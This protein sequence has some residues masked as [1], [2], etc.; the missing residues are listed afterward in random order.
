[1]P[2]SRRWCWS[3][4]IAGNVGV[5]TARVE[6]NSPATQSTGFKKNQLGSTNKIHRNSYQAHE[7]HMHMVCTSLE[8]VLLVDLSDK[9]LSILPKNAL[10]ESARAVPVTGTR[11]PNDVLLMY[12]VTLQ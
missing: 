1:M 5:H 2:A 7:E 9:D 8:L 6:L 3:Y 10:S 4:G 11:T 12:R